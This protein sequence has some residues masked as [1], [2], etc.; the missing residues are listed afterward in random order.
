MRRILQHRGLRVAVSIALLAGVG[1]A[2]DLGSVGRQLATARALPLLLALS[3]SV[4]V[5][6]A[7]AWRWVFTARRMGLSL[8]FRTAWG[9]YY[10]STLLNQVLPGGVVGDVGRAVRGGVRAPQQRGAVAR[11]VVIERVSGQLA[12]W[13]AVAVGT[14]AWG[15]EY[16]PSIAAVVVAAVIGI[17][18]IVSLLPRVPAVRSSGLGRA[19]LRLRTELRSAL[20]DRGAWAIQLLASLLPLVLLGGMFTACVL[21]VGVDVGWL[22]ML[23][24]AP[25]ILAATSIPLSVGGWGVRE[26]VSAA[27]FELVG[28]SAADGVAASAAFGVVNLVASLPGV[29]FLFSRVADPEPS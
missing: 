11:C 1:Y 13:G 26:V 29:V 23:L 14:A 7:M 10:L 27:L 19:I 25:L 28:L 8:S 18:A 9:E 5:I 6:A 24:V 4:P 12:L 21:A 15:V 20:L 22:Q 2:V 16:G 17:W 3:M